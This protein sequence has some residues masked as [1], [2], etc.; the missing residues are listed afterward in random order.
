VGKESQADS[1]FRKFLKSGVGLLVAQLISFASIPFIT[2]IY[3]PEEFT[4]WLV[5][6]TTVCIIGSVAS[7]RYEL[8]IVIPKEDENASAIFWF[9]GVICAVTVI[10]FSLALL[11]PSVKFLITGT[12]DL[13][14]IHILI[15]YMIF[16]FGINMAVQNWNIRNELYLTISFSEATK[17][18]FTV[19]GQIYF[20]TTFEATG[21]WLI[22]GSGV[23]FT[24]GLLAQ[25]SG[26][27]RSRPRPFM[28][29]ASRIPALVREHSRFLFYS[30]PYTFTFL[31]AGRGLIY[32]MNHYVGGSLAGAY[33][34]AERILSAPGNLLSAAIRPV[35]FRE[36][37]AKGI[38]SLEGKVKLIMIAIL[39]LSAP[40]VIA[41]IVHAEPIMTLLLGENWND[42]P[43]I[44]CIIVWVAFTFLFCNWM[45]R[46]YDVMKLQRMSLIM[47]LVSSVIT[48]GA[49]WASLAGGLRFTHALIIQT[50][51]IVSYNVLYI[52]I[53]YKKAKWSLAPLVN[54]SI[55][56][57]CISLF[58]Y[59]SLK[60]LDQYLTPLA[61]TAIFFIGYMLVLFIVF[62][63]HDA[64]RS[65]IKEF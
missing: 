49:L 19:L 58:S 7:L 63:Y 15:P 39:A 37:A 33:G 17:I 16:I 30:M 36:A 25:C 31:L 5:S 41:L 3:P 64:F 24:V 28:S 1:L 57:I 53:I 34:L 43:E 18:I 6:I 29:V 11:L 20:G 38:E 62:Y 50:T 14:I 59:V 48:I 2:R 60:S 10:I 26:L 47:Q 65:Q 12:Q 35:L 40:C 46:L 13:K 55:W 52:I 22:I 27:T 51:L 42:V 45:D 8:A 4:I 56:F 9:C 44:A 21:E 32:L 54:V 61:G 23:G